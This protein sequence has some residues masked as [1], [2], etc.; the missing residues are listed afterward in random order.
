MLKY[1]C[2][3]YCML[4]WD[5]EHTEYHKAL[6]SLES[7]CQDDESANYSIR[8]PLGKTDFSQDEMDRAKEILEKAVNLFGCVACDGGTASGYHLADV[9]VSCVSMARYAGLSNAT[10]AK[11]IGDIICK[12]KK[13]KTDGK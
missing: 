7:E 1:Q 4:I 9:I 10:L 11:E 2:A 5:D 13:N 3:D 8:I 12:Q 6:A